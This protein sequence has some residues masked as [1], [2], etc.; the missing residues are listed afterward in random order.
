MATLGARL[1]QE[2]P[3]YAETALS[4]V[5]RHGSDF[6]T[7][8]MIAQTVEQQITYA[9]KIHTWWLS[10][11]E[12]VTD[13]TANLELNKIFFDQQVT[14]DELRALLLALQG[15]TISFKTFYDRLANTG[16]SREGIDSDEEL[17]DIAADGDQF[18]PEDKSSEQTEAEK[19]AGKTGTPKEKLKPKKKKKT[20]TGPDG[21]VK[22]QITTEDEED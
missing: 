11:E 17:A 5:M 12:L 19:I 6:A 20:V 22:Y 18:K 10:T 13:M 7:L 4:V 8:R 9:L 14:A 3:K 15:G 16:W 2:P 21:K 1:L